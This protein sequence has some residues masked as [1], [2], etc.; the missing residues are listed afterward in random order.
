MDFTK[1]H[2]S[3]VGTKLLKRYAGMDGDEVWGLQRY[4]RAD[5]IDRNTTNPHND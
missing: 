4:S 5:N 3:G 1:E 2:A